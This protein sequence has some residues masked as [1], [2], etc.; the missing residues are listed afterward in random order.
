MGG[1][2]GGAKGASTHPRGCVDNWKQVEK[3][4]PNVNEETKVMGK[5]ETCYI[6]V[7]LSTRMLLIVIDALVI[8]WESECLSRYTSCAES[9]FTFFD[10]TDISIS[11][12]LIFGFFLQAKVMGCGLLRDP[13]AIYEAVILVVFS[14]FGTFIYNLGL[15]N[16]FPEQEGLSHFLRM[17]RICRVI[18]LIRATEDL[19]TF[20]YLDDL[21]LLVRGLR[22]SVQTLLSSVVMLSLVVFTTSVI[23]TAYVGQHDDTGW[24]EVSLRYKTENFS[25]VWGSMQ[26]LFRFVFVDDAADV[27]EPLSRDLIFLW[28]MFM[29]FILVSVFLVMNLIMAVIVNQAMVFT[30]NDKEHRA[31]QL[32]KEKEHYT[33]KVIRFFNKI[34]L[35]GNAKLTYGEFEKAFEHPE[36]RNDLLAVGVEVNELRELFFILDTSN[37]GELAVADFVTGMQRIRSQATSRDLLMISQYTR[38]VFKL[39]MAIKVKIT[40][41]GTGNVDGEAAKQGLVRQKLAK[42]ETDVDGTRQLARELCRMLDD[43]KSRPYEGQQGRSGAKAGK[44]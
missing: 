16:M 14:I 29:L 2:K 5:L 4:R 39:L 13:L 3:V 41:K 18:L 10:I 24:S 31:K 8:G 42:L 25:S 35:D 26:V 34:D 40:A 44:G 12:F 19:R 21:Y 17:G 36:I 38:R 28:Y 32:Q 1:Q 20:P 7:Y 9:N 23:V 15:K 27:I 30:K 22:D 33:K 11:I 43:R 37:T 6:Q